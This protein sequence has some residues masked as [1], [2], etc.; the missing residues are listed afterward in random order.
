MNPDLDKLFAYPFVCLEQLLAANRPPPGLAPISLTIGEPRHAP[1]EAVLAALREAEAGYGAYPMALG[2]T[3]LRLACAGWLARRYQLPEKLL[4]PDRQLLPVSGTREALFA[5]AQ[6][7]VDRT[8]PNPKVLLPNPFYQI[9]EG[10]ALLAGAE[11]V[12]LDASAATDWLPD[13]NLVDADTWRDCQLLYLCSPGNPTGAVM[14]TAYLEHAL[15]LADQYDFVIAADECYAELYL[16]EQAPPPGILAVAA[17]SGR[18]SLRNVVAF[19]SLS[20][21]SNLPGLR[22]G[23]VAGDADVMQ[24]FLLYRTYHGCAMPLPAQAASVV[25]WQD[26][27]HVQANRSLYRQKF[28]RVVP[29]LNEVLDFAPPAATFYLWASCGCDDEVFT[30]ELHAAE[31]VKVLPGQYLSRGSGAA[32]PG[33]QRIRI[34]LVATVEECVTAAERIARFVKGRAAA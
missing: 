27:A 26:D 13:L 11:P 3:E 29:I 20:K 1:P 28:A 19:H 22:S 2:L 10:A 17:A 18:E 31:N 5:F 34:S 15:D 14:D 30:R 21:R 23:F 7:V 9:Y 12:Y 16:E 24:K 4:D 8:R 6:A 33:W 32:S 25:A